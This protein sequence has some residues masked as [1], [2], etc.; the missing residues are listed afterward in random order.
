MLSAFEFL[1]HGCI[2][3]LRG[4]L[5]MTSPLTEHPFYVVIETSGSNAAHDEEKLTSYLESVMGS[6]LV[7][8]GTIATDGTKIKVNLAGLTSLVK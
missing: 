4:N 2:E 7:T 8:D 6:G 5:G 1:D 3:S